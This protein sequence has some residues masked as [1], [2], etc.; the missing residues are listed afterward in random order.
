MEAFKLIKGIVD[1]TIFIKNFDLRNGVLTGSYTK[2]NEE[3]VFNP[4]GEEIEKF[5]DGITVMANK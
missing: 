4:H 1:D 2:D 3:T 5:L